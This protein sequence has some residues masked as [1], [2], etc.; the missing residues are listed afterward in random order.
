[1]EGVQ[2]EGYISIYERHVLKISGMRKLADEMETQ[3]L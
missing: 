1:M 2:V 3:C